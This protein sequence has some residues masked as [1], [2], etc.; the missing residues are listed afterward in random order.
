MIDHIDRKASDTVHQVILLSK[1]V[2]FD[3]PGFVI[4]WICSFITGRSQQYKIDNELSAI[5][6]IELSIVQG[7]AIGPT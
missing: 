4:N 5:A 6:D 3:L 2:K 7:S 1:L